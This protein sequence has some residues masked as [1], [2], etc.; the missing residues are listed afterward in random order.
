M[1]AKPSKKTHL[2][3]RLSQRKK[4]TLPRPTWGEALLKQLSSLCYLAVQIGH[5]RAGAIRCG[6]FPKKNEHLHPL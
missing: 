5:F 4:D 6:P 2:T 3:P 1:T